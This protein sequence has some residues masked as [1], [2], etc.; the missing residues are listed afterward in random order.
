MGANSKIEWTHHTFNP[1][2]GCAKVSPGCVSCYAESENCRYGRHLWGPDAP[3]QRTSEPYWRQPLK[4]N[5][6]AEREGQRHRVFC[7]SWC[8]VMEAGAYLSE[9][10]RDLWPLIC[11]TLDLDWL[12]LTK[13]PENYAAL[14][15][16]A[17]LKRP[18]PNVWLGTTVEDRARRERIDVLR[19]VPAALRFLS[20]E[21]LLEDLGE[22]DLR[23][24]GCV[25]VGGESGPRARPCDLAWIRDILRQCRESGVPVFVK[26][27]GANPIRSSP[28]GATVEYLSYRDR[29]GANPEEWPADLLV[30]EIPLPAAGPEVQRG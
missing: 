20:V 30:R 8:D 12:L 17:W 14:L 21:P 4:W 18:W 5:A 9:I 15:P 10:R 28:G 24:I 11:Q 23:G 29:K 19:E 3:R 6:A 27:L 26:Q 13:R 22:L 25:I 1:W 16:P 7:G 2:M